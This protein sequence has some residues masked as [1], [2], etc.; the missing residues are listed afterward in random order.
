M[1]GKV[2]PDSGMEN[3]RLPSLPGSTDSTLSDGT[4]LSYPMTTT[5]SQADF[6]DLDKSA[7]KS[8]LFR[9]LVFGLLLYV[10]NI[11]LHFA[12]ASQYLGMR[13][14]HRG[15]SHTL[16]DFKLSDIVK[17]NETVHEPGGDLDIDAQ[18][19]VSSNPMEAFVNEQLFI[20]VRNQL[21]SLIPDH[22]VQR[23]MGIVQFQLKEYKPRHIARLCK[24]NEQ[25]FDTTLALGAYICQDALSEE[26]RMGIEEIFHDILEGDEDQILEAMMANDFE[27][28]TQVIPKSIGVEIPANGLLVMNKITQKL[29]PEELG[30]I[31]VFMDDPEVA[32]KIAPMMKALS[33]VDPVELDRMSKTLGKINPKNIPIIE[34]K[35]KPLNLTLADFVTNPSVLV[36]F[37][38]K[39]QL[40]SILIEVQG[41]LPLFMPSDINAVLVVKNSFD[42]IPGAGKVLGK[43]LKLP[44][45]L[46]TKV[47]SVKFSEDEMVT[48]QVLGQSFENPKAKR[49]FKVVQALNL[50]NENTR[51][52]AMNNLTRQCVHD[53]LKVKCEDKTKDLC[54]N[55]HLYYA[56]LTLISLAVPGALFAITEFCHFKSFRF[57]S[58]FGSL[59][60]VDMSPA[61][62]W[63][64]LPFYIVIMIPLKF[65]ITIVQYYRVL[66]KIFHQRSPTK[67]QD[68]YDDAVNIHSLEASSNS[69]FQV[70]IQIYFLLLLV[71]FGT[72]TIISGVDAL[73][74]LKAIVPLTVASVFFSTFN[75]IFMAWKLQKLDH[76][77]KNLQHFESASSPSSSASSSSFLGIFTFLAWL[78]ST[79]LAQIFSLILM[80][81]IMWIEVL[82]GNLSGFAVTLSV[83]F[84]PVFLLFLAFPLNFLYHR[85]YVQDD[86]MYHHAHGIL[87]AIF[88]S[89]YFNQNDPTR[90]RDF[91]VFN[92]L[93]HWSIHILAWGVYSAIIY[94]F[95]NEE[96]GLL[97]ILPLIVAFMT[98]GPVFGAIHWVTH[99]KPCYLSP[100]LGKSSSNELE[101]MGDLQGTPKKTL[102]K[103]WQIVTIV[104]RLVSLALM[105]F[106]F[107]EHF[108][109]VGSGLKLG[110]V[111]ALPYILLLAVTN[112]GLQFSLF[113]GSVRSGL[114]SIM[115]PN[116]YQNGSLNRAGR[117]IIFNVSLNLVL[118]LTLWLNL[119]FY[120]WECTK[121]L[122]KYFRKLSVCF[123]LSVGLWV[124][125]LV[126]TLVVWR[127]CIRKSVGN[128]VGSGSD[129]SSST[130]SRHSPKNRNE[131]N[132]SAWPAKIE[133][134]TTKF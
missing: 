113:G 133:S 61:L 14:C 34:E 92:Q 6:L 49:L 23:I 84:A 112:V 90:T 32:S 111:Y 24:F 68:C 53:R 71:V 65:L 104:T 119:T 78:V 15:I 64:L 93:T 122:D 126:M 114:F 27:K 124:L 134:L 41:L 60:G 106:V 118:H 58:L 1:P 17:L 98:F 79:K 105:G 56:I 85:K 42:S 74:V 43:V 2:R 88:P 4:S 87:S 54:P 19:G 16:Y 44:F 75:Y 26:N 52:E 51:L 38:Q 83:E 47:M 59:Y 82:S 95:H 9:V 45:D 40:A 125:S 121:I 13:E 108:I 28:L 48:M 127:L 107:F 25:T 39:P 96:A 116:G 103:A 67:I 33:K 36:R 132:T 55:G 117:F 120:C 123:P 18:H 94:S 97:R 130:Q 77:V 35:L 29:S 62:K 22:W 115:V 81:L 100:V 57:G 129:L 11:G 86:E 72:G 63:L 73:D 110:F 10:V 31:V 69:F 70:V 46:V 99:I 66:K 30:I 21:I 128:P 89:R 80:A 37:I 5:S 20:K 109:E 102:F 8:R 50:L 12:I 3:R 91:L 131:E 76:R 101:S 7:S